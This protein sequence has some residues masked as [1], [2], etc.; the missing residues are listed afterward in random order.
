VTLLALATVILGFVLAFAGRRPE[1]ARGERSS[2]AAI[3]EELAA[4]ERARA[5]GDVGPKT[6]ERGRRE[7]IVA[8]AR[9]LS[10]A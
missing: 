6:Y 2:R 4:L 3:L 1:P 5:A 10:S 9:A 7:L 8:L